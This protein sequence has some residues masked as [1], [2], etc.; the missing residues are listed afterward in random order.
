MTFTLFLLIK[1]GFLF[2]IVSKSSRAKLYSLCVC[3]KLRSRL[4]PATLNQKD[5][6]G[7]SAQWLGGCA[8]L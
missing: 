7:G 4:G 5:R 2:C 8:I 6:L 3:V 1:Y